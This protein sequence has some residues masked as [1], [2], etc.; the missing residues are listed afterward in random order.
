[1]TPTAHRVDLYAHIHKALRLAMCDSLR[2]L[3]CLDAS[4]PLDLAATLGQLDA[5]LTAAQHH[6][7]KEN[8]FV[9]PA[10][11]AR[12]AGASAAI[13][14]EHEEHLDSI[15]TL[16]AEAA[17]LREVSVILVVLFGMRYLKEPFGRPRLIA[18]GLVLIGMLVMKL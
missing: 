12:R 13:E 1:M 17:A 14:A 3:S 7:E 18:C 9:H 15:A 11:E 10:I 8:R 16:R 2:Q 5:V 4:D 6:V